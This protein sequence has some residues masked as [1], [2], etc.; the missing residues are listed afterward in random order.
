MG[1]SNNNA[2]KEVTAL[3]LKI[4]TKACKIQFIKQKLTELGVY[5]DIIKDSTI[6]KNIY[7]SLHTKNEL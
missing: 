5:K 6:I 3:N 4:L 1:K 7:Q 2:T